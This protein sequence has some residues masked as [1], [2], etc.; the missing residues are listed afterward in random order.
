MSEQEKDQDNQGFSRPGGSESGESRNG[1]TR[2]RG[3]ILEDAIL[4]GAWQELSEVGY[5]RLT[6]EGVA[7]RARTKDL[8]RYELLITQEQL[9]E[10]TLTEIINDIFMPLVRQ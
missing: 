6:M 7:A 1:R 9:T 10:E 5:N 3:Q 4:E 2:R 8:F